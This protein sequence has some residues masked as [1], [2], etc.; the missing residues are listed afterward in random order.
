VIEPNTYLHGKTRLGAN[1]R[2]GPNTIIRD[3]TIGDGCIILSSDLTEATIEENVHI[4]PYARL[5][6][7][8]HLARNVFMGN[9][10]EIKNSYIGEG[11]HIGHFSYIGDSQLGKNVNIGAGTITCNF[12]GKQKNRTVIGD[13]VFIGSDTMLIAPVTI[14]S[15]ARTG[16]G[17]VVNKDVPPHS[18]A[19]GSPARIIRK[20][21]A[22]Q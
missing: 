14:G 7:G 18:L 2:V 17:T 10:G 16:A 22:G 19:V 8:A 21:T 6:S 4:G 5:R 12:D 13:D 15:G 1:C 3:S 20:L 11:S 9:Y